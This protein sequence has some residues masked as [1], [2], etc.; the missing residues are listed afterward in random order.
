MSKC[1]II[2][3]DDVAPLGIEM[4]YW[5]YNDAVV[6]FDDWCKRYPF[7]ELYLYEVVNYEQADEKPWVIIDYRE[8]VYTKDDKE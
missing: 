4:D 5:V 2:Y 1:W 6:A 3:S 7:A 8:G